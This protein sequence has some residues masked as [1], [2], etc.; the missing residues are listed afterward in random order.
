MIPESFAAALGIGPQLAPSVSLP[1]HGRG[2]LPL[3]YDLCDI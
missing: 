3:A 1:L 2:T